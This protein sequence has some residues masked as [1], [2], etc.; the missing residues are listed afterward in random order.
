[1][2]LLKRLPTVDAPI[3]TD[4]LSGFRALGVYVGLVFL[5][6]TRGRPNEGILPGF[7]LSG[8]RSVLL[9][10]PSFVVLGLAALLEGI[11]GIF[12][13]HHLFKDMGWKAGTGPEAR[14]SVFQ[15]YR[16]MER[17]SFLSFSHHG[18]FIFTIHHGL[19]LYTLGI[20][21]GSTFS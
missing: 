17:L 14:A 5:T 18:C 15:P 10:F 21:I 4:G 1:M 2:R 6:V 12:I 13:Y 9:S 16:G 19:W 20:L 3:G 7:L 11:L 8:R